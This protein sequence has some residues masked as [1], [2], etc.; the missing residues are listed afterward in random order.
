MSSVPLTCDGVLSEAAANAAGPLPRSISNAKP[1]GPRLRGD[2][3]GSVR[4]RHAMRCSAGTMGRFARRPGAGRGPIPL[5]ARQSGLAE[6]QPDPHRLEERRAARRARR[7]VVLHRRGRDVV[8]PRPTL[9]LGPRP[10]PGRRCAVRR[11]HRGAADLP[12]TRMR[13]H[14]SVRRPADAARCIDRSCL[15]RPREGG[16]QVSSVPLTCGGVLSEATASALPVR[17]LDPSPCKSLGPRLRGDDSGSVRTSCSMPAARGRCALCSS[18]RRWPGPKL[19]VGGPG[20][21]RPRPAPGRRCAVRRAHRGAADL[22]KT[23]MRGHASV[24]RPADAAR[25]IDRS[26]LRRPREGGDQVSSVPLTCGGVLSE[27]TASALPVRYLDPSPCKSLGPRLRGD[28]SGSVRTSCSMPA[29]RGR[30][31][32]CSSPR[33]SRGPIP[34]CARQ[35]G[36]AEAQP[37]PHRL[38][39]R[40]AARR[41]RRG[42]VLHRRGRDVV[43]PRPHFYLGPGLRRGDMRDRRRPRAAGHRGS[44]VSAGRRPGAGRGPIPL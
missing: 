7:G 2:D 10:A 18:P 1:L 25:C 12:K 36:L 14:A 26:C 33:R 8:R 20:E 11:A 44:W 37:D 4:T 16:D 3:S 6:A 17:Y 40:R 38:E 35:S 22:P 23:R 34:L 27:A 15:R 30:C 13:G 43:S 41:A 42:V 24:R 29:A 31:A 39:Q 19:I 32:L 9:L 28:D 21:I 5:C